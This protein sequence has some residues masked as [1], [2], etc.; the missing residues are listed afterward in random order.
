MIRIRKEN[1]SLVYGDYKT[2]FCKDNILVFERK[3]DNDTIIVAI[4]NNYYNRDI[5]INISGI[6]RDL[7]SDEVLDIS[8]KLNLKR[9]KFLILK[10]I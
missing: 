10:K 3:Y 1:K 8:N 9:M 6:Y 4:N 5:L 7:Y 2:L